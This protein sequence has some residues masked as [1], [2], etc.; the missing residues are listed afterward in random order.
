MLSNGYKLP[1]KGE[2]YE[3]Q[4]AQRSKTKRLVPKLFVAFEE[5]LPVPVS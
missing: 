2:V 5:K 1:P 3:R 4:V